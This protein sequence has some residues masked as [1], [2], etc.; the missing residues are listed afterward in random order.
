MRKNIQSA[1]WT[2]LFFA[3]AA[4]TATSAIAGVNTWQ[5][6]GDLQWGTSGNWSTG[7]IP[8]S[9]DTAL[10]PTSGVNS[11]VVNLGGETRTVSSLISSNAAYSFTNGTIS[12]DALTFC[13]GNVSAVLTGAASL[14]KNGSGTL[15]L[16]ATNSYTGP[17]YLNAGTL[18]VGNS[19]AIGTNAVT[20]AAG[21]SLGGL[22]TALSANPPIICNGSFST[23]N[24]AKNIDFGTGAVTI[25]TQLTI[26]VANGLVIGGPITG[27][28]N[29]NACDITFAQAAGCAYSVTLSAP[30]TLRANQTANWAGWTTTVNGSVG[31]NSNGYSLTKAGVG[32]MSLTAANTYSGDTT[33]SGG[34]IEVRSNLALQNSAI[35]AASNTIGLYVTSPTFGGLRGSVNLASV[36]ST[37]FGSVTALTLNP[38]A[39]HTNTYSGV[40]TNG[41]SSLTLTKS[42]AGTQV[43]S[44]IN[45]FNGT[46]TVNNGV[47]RLS[48][49]SVLG[50]NTTIYLTTPAGS[51]DLAFNGT[52]KI[53]ALY[54]NGVKQD[55]ETYGSSMS[56]ITGT[57]SLQVGPMLQGPV[58]RFH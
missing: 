8:G 53:A 48:N 23:A 14:S 43:L 34:K 2:A 21:T 31:D 7:A 56:N 44:G 25:N 45:V 16:S 26:T 41:N 37:G 46:L 39:D 4:L 9:A 19:A 57:G 38:G 17:A 49:A 3:L 11:G 54:V 24:T 20:I 58:M 36:F 47:L 52:L 5:N 6:G 40:L 35:N 28:G 50:T 1:E 51:L 29:L 18:I 42:G 12:A 15:T 32:T 10:F 33:I 55:N 27:P 22:N 13:G 30:I